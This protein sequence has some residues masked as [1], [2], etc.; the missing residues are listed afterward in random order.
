MPNLSQRTV[1]G[2]EVPVR[3]LHNQ[4]NIWIQKLESET[5]MLPAR[6]WGTVIVRALSLYWVLDLI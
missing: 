2:H 3:K 6:L 5:E 4:D 1:K